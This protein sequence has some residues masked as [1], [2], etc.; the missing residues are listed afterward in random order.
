MKKILRSFTLLALLAIPWAVQAQETIPFSYGFE[1]ADAMANWTVVSGVSSTAIMT[2]GHESANCYGFY[3]TTNPPQY[4]ISPE[5][6]DVNAQLLVSFWYNIRSTSYPE[7]F[8][9]GYSTTTNDVE[10]FTWGDAITASS[11]SWTQYTGQAPAGTKYVAI[12]CTSYDAFTLYIDDIEVSNASTYCFAASGL[13]T[14]AFTDNSITVAWTDNSEGDA[15]YTLRYWFAGAGEDD[16]V[17]VQNLSVFTYAAENLEANTAYTF[18]VTTNCASGNSTPVTDSFR[19]ACGTLT[20]PYTENWEEFATSGWNDCWLRPI[21]TGTY[22]TISNYYHHGTGNGMRLQSSYSEHYNLAV[23]PAIP[24]PGNMIYVDFWAYLSDNTDWYGDEYESWI[25]AGVMTNPNDTSTFIPLLTINDHNFNEEFREYEFNTST[26]DEDATYYVAFLYYGED[27]YYVTAGLDDIVIRENNGCNRPTGLATSDITADG[28]TLTWVAEEGQ[29]EWMVQIGEEE[30]VSVSGEPTYTFGDLDA[31]TPYTARVAT[32]CGDAMSDYVSI[33]F[34]T[35]CANGSCEITVEMHDQYTD[36]WNGGAVRAYQNGALSGSATIVTGNSGTETINVCKGIPV[37][38]RLTKGSYPGEM[39][40]TIFDGGGVEI[41]SVAQGTYSSSTTEDLVIATVENACPSCM[42][43]TGVATSETTSESLTFVWDDSDEV[44]TYL[45]SFNGGEY[46]EGSNGTVTVDGL[47]ENTLYTFS[48]KAVCDPGEDTSSAATIS[49]R[50]A[51]GT[52][53]L[54]YTENWESFGVPNQGTWNDCW[55][56]PLMHNTDPSINAQ[57]HHGEGNYG[58]YLYANNGYNLAVSPQIPLPGNMIYVDFWAYLSDNT[59]WYGDEY[60]SWL[61]AGVMTDPNDTTTFIPLLTINDH[62]FNNEFREYEFNTSTLDEDATYYVAF[63]FYGANSGYTYLTGGLD[64]IVIRENNGCNRPTDLAVSDITADGA[65]LT[66]VAEEGQS[67]WMVQI[68]EE[69]PVSVSGE[70]TYTFSGLDARTPYTARV[71]TVC[72]DAMSDY[73]S[74]NFTTDCASGSCN[75]TIAA[76]DSYGDGWNNSTLNFYQNGVLASSYSMPSQSLYNTTIYDTATV[77]VCTGIPVTFSWQSAS[78]YDYEA[79]YVIY[80]G[81]FV[82]VYS[83]SSATDG[84][85]HSDTIDNPCPSCLAPANVRAVDADEHS[86]TIAWDVDPDV[87]GYIVSFD[88]G[89]YE[90]ATGGTYTASGLDAS[91]LHTFSVKTVCVANQDTSAA[92]TISARTSCGAMSLPYYENFFS[93]N[94]PGTLPPCWTYDPNYVKW[95]IY[96][97]TT[98]NGEM[99]FG[100]QSGYKPAVLPVLDG[101]FGKFEISFKVKC[102]PA[103]QGDS[104]LIGVADALGENIEWVAR[105][106]NPNQSQASWVVHTYSLRDYH[107][108]GTRIVLGRTLNAEGAKWAAIDDINVMQVDGAPAPD[109]LVANNLGDATNT[110]FSWHNRSN[111][112]QFQVYL[113]TVTV[114]I[115]TVPAAN[116]ITITESNYTIPSDR[117]VP[118][119]KYIFYVRSYCGENDFSDW[120]A[121]E[122]GANAV[123]MNDMG[124]GGVAD[125]VTGCGFVVYDNGGPIA[126]YNPNSNSA[127]VILPGDPNENLSVYG[128]IF[129][130]GDDAATLTIYDGVGTTGDVLYTFDQIGARDTLRQVLATSTEHALTITFVVYGTRVHTGYELYVRCGDGSGLNPGVGIDEVEE[131]DIV[132]FPNPASTTVTLRG[133]EENATVTVVDMNG[134]EVVK[135]HNK[136]IDVSHM[137]KGAYF[138]R[139]VGE[140]TS[141]IRKLIVK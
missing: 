26:L 35:D 19:T 89:Q 18:E 105:L 102:M 49:V 121:Y 125:T 58:L 137:A 6:E 99:M 98:G 27:S 115:E 21:S 51:C 103:A 109:S 130:W 55:L 95:N 104:I 119:G 39:S 91:T 101:D 11:Q 112:S 38:F 73:V 62:N 138:V 78:S 24:L 13:T 72:G 63:L 23:S 70:P 66:W 140:Q 12:K 129:G 29:S 67:A 92:R 44:Y 117:M 15:T 68:G 97:G 37:E 3:Y 28:A 60:E 131:N 43:P 48:V 135:T 132:L 113:D 50:T 40:F 128:G 61:K 7:T 17:T 75:I 53:T 9:V 127:L 52:L 76:Q 79:S 136:T 81:G 107:G 126:G 108:T 54:P 14:T 8:Q 87:A 69:E 32:V 116:L 94:D 31:R 5:L 118:G 71:A 85:N 141:A 80:D 25:K 90:P 111:C 46:E 110:S 30:P 134:R 84:V 96:P 36:G 45:V 47:T 120:T 74:I 124:T 64:D 2:G 83:S 42:P 123:I 139:V 100:A 133:M 20:L 41:I 59:D 65:T 10:S 114:D 34:T 57:Y 56:R 77:N 16:T 106:T 22:P 122:F 93:E 4:L 86:I 88:G 82:E 1:E 33:S